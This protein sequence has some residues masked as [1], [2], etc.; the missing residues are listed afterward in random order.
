MTFYALSIS[1]FQ[2]V[3]CCTCSSLDLQ[4]LWLSSWECCYTLSENISVKK[5]DWYITCQCR[6]SLRTT[7]HRLVYCFFFK[8]FIKYFISVILLTI[9]SCIVYRRKRILYRMCNNCCPCPANNILFDQAE[10]S[11]H[12]MYV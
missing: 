7:L 5:V 10:L 4:L 12:W 9:T 1:F 6:S 11:E 2:H 8:F 3:T